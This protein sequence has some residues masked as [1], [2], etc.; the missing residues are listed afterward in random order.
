MADT[1][2]KN[3]PSEGK[4]G[5]DIPASPTSS[6][7][8]DPGLSSG[9]VPGSTADTQTDPAPAPVLPVLD[10]SQGVP[11]PAVD[12]ATN[13]GVDGHPI[14]GDDRS[15][16]PVRADQPL[17]DNPG[18][19]LED[20]PIDVLAAGIDTPERSPVTG[21]LQATSIDPITGVN[22]DKVPP[23]SLAGKPVHALFAPPV[24]DPFEH[25]T[26]ARITV[27][28]SAK[29]LMK[30]GQELREELSTWRGN[31]PAVP[32]DEMTTEELRQYLCYLIFCANTGVSSTKWLAWDDEDLW[33][34]I[35]HDNIQFAPDPTVVAV[36]E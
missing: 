17:Y 1:K 4:D 20:R 28:I 29:Y 7:E 23:I 32:A 21:I 6:T 35:D 2:P 15:E 31:V 27:P 34:D 5:K 9:A 10:L 30:T 25:E 16:Q 14:Q 3:T 22:I 13:T 18:N 8:V 33:F 36:A 24:E 11:P 26:K 19:D 12:Q